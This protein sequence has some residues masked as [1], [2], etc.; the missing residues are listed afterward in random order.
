MSNKKARQQIMEYVT[1]NFDQ[2]TVEPG[3]IKMN[4]RCHD[5]SVHYAKKNK[6]S[7]LAMCVY[8]DRNCPV[9]HFVNYNK[10]RFKDNTLGQWTRCYD[11]YFIK[12]IRDEEMWDIHDIFTNYRKH[13]GKQLSWWVRL[14]S[15]FRG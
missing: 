7:K 4:F 14:T 11:Y 13:L 2:I 9:I 8:I 10:G 3:K 12:W 5:N 6:H 15:D 1:S